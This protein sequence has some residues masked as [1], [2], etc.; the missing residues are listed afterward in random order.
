MKLF[1]TSYLAGTKGLAQK[2]LAQTD[3]QNILFIPTAANVE[4]YR[5]YVDEGIAALKEMG[6]VVA[7][8]DVATTPHN[9]SVQAIKNSDCLCV[10]G[11][12]TFFLLQELKRNGLLDLI[13]QKVQD[14]IPYIGESAGA[15][16]ACPDIAYNQ[17]MDD[18][19][20]ATE[21]TDY[22]GM[23]LVDYYV[24]PHNGEFPF[25]ETTAQTIKVYGEK[26]N[27]VPLNNSQA[28]VVEGKKSAVLTEE[29]L[30]K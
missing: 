16:I 7:I 17:I 27:L 21:L 19:T 13:K 20:V 30:S 28:V 22:S 1:L 4:E 24:L 9:E 8:L 18:K 26:I 11:G 25:V 3:M 23:D 29:S 15:I 14:G 6:C 12:N 10:S 5:G 2:F